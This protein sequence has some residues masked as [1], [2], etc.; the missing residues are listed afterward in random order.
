MSMDPYL[1]DAGQYG[2]RLLT[3]QAH[4]LFKLF[5]PIWPTR[6]TGTRTSSRCRPVG[7]S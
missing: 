5:G 3:D 1:R 6:E 4:R 2:L 7:Q